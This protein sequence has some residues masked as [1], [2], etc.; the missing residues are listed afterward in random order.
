M[1]VICCSRAELENGSVHIMG[2]CTVDPHESLTLL[3]S[4]DILNFLLHYSGFTKDSMKLVQTYRT[5]ER[6]EPNPNTAAIV[7]AKYQYVQYQVLIDYVS[8]RLDRL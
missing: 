6:Y 4:S 5:S 1:A 7:N 3:D 2:R 8:D